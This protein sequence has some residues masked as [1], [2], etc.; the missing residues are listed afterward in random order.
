MSET[1]ETGTAITAQL[2]VRGG[3][4]HLWDRELSVLVDA[5]DLTTAYERLLEKRAQARQLADAGGGPGSR[6]SGGGWPD[7]A[8]RRMMPFFIKAAVVALVGVVLLSAASISFSYI[9]RGEPV[10]NAAWRATRATID[11]A[12]IGIEWFGREG[13]TADRERRLK[14]AL[15]AAVPVLKPY[16]DE[17]RPLFADTNLR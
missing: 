14:V 12:T 11:N 1:D 4:F 16:I 2:L 10:R 9:T 8:V 15:R 5:G 7:S 6:G 3:K 13:M 17:L